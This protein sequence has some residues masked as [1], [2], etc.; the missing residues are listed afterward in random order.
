MLTWPSKEM[1]R[2]VSFTTFTPCS[3]PS[4]R[5]AAHTTFAANSVPEQSNSMPLNINS[6]ARIR[7]N[8]LETLP[9]IWFIA[10]II[11]GR[12]ASRSCFTVMVVASRTRF[13]TT[14]S[15]LPVS[16]LDK[17]GRNL[18]SCFNVNV[19]VSF[20]SSSTRFSRSFHSLWTKQK[21]M[22]HEL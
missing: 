17:S 12:K 15:S 4:L 11:V 20:E 2:W 21:I 8:G 19:M 9:K 7:T 1:E 16:P 10:L 22:Q 13:G 3:L 14:T 5:I 6:I 18:K